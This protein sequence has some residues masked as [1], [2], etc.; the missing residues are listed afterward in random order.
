MPLRAIGYVSQA[1]QPWD[2]ETV[3]AMVAGSV[4]FN[5]QAG[6]TGVLF[7]DGIRYLRYLEGPDDGLEIAYSRIRASTLHSDVMELARGHIGRR[8]MPYWSMRWLLADPSHTRTMV[9]AD[10][11]GFILSP[12]RKG[13]PETAMEHVHGYVEPYLWARPSDAQVARPGVGDGQA[14]LA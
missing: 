13:T 5:L 6:V 1:T 2:R 7:F 9:G 10:W 8:L 3:E 12:G 14:R 4:A 11:T